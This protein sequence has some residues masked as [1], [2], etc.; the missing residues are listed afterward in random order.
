MCREGL[1]GE[2]FRTKKFKWKFLNLFYY[3]A[4]QKFATWANESFNS[5]LSLF[6]FKVLKFISTLSAFEIKKYST[7]ETLR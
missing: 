7:L 5:F 1:R 6:R 2:G 3:E 4:R